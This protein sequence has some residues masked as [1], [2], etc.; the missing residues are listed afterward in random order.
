MQ[1]YICILFSSKHFYIINMIVQCIFY[2]SWFLFKKKT[3]KEH[4]FCAFELLQHQEQKGD[5]R[6]CAFIYLSDSVCLLQQYLGW[7]EV[8]QGFE[9]KIVGRLN[10]KDPC[11]VL[12]WSL[13]WG[14]N[15][16]LWLTQTFTT[17]ETIAL[18]WFV[19]QKLQNLGK[20]V[21]VWT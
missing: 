8:V 6:K 15:V 20:H 9:I 16:V 2:G 12:V 21:V 14:I 13:F 17:L 10:S 4:E 5:C 1:R 11:T 18:R 19:E 3:E 7:F